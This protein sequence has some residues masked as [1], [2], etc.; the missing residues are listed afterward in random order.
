LVYNIL[1]EDKIPKALICSENEAAGIDSSLD[2]SATN[3]VQGYNTP[4][5]GDVDKQKVLIFP[6]KEA[7]GIDL[8]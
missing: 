7:A 8:S 4:K 1:E 5:S 6:E 2:K 3:L